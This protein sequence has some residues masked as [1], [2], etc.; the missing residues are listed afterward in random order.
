MITRFCIAAYTRT[1]FNVFFAGELCRLVKCDGRR[2]REGA[3]GDVTTHP[4][5]LSNL[6][7]TEHR[8]AIA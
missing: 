6:A 7:L 4:I 1:P 2:V 3:C 8:S 5:P